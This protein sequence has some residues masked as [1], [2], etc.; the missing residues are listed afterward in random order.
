[1]YALGAVT[2]E[3]LTGEPPFSGATVQAIVAKVLTEKPMSPTAVRDTVPRHIEATLLKAL[4]KLPADRFAT[5]ALFAESLAR[6]EMMAATGASTAG[7]VTGTSP[8][9]GLRRFISA[10]PGVWV[11]L[12][13]SIGLAGWGWNR[14]AG[15]AAPQP[16]TR[17][18]MRLGSATILPGLVNPAISP[19]GS[20][21][22]FV[23][24]D[25]MGVTRIYVRTL[26]RFDPVTVSGTEGA[27]LPF[28]SPD[29]ESIGF[30]QDGKLRTVSLR[31]GTVIP[32]CDWAVP[33]SGA[34]WGDDSTIV[35]AAA[36]S[37][38]RVPATGG[39]PVLL[40]AGFAG[41]RG[42][43][44]PS[45]LP[46]GRAVLAQAIGDNAGVVALR[47][48]DSTLTHLVPDGT[49]PQYV[50]G[51]LL[52]YGAADGSV[53]AAPFDPAS[54][55]I[56]GPAEPVTD[57]VAQG[58]AGGTAKFAVA[59]TG[60]LAY[61]TGSSAGGR[62]LV[63]TDRSG[64]AR[65]LPIGKRFYRFPR[66]SPDG[67]QL[68]FHAEV[69]GTVA[70]DLWR[71]TFDGGALIRLTSDSVS[72]QPEW[73]PDGR[74]L[75]YIRRVAG[76]R[77]GAALQ[78]YRVSADG[79]EAPRPVLA[80]PNSIYESRITPDH[81]MIVFREDAAGGGGAGNRDI[82]MAP[83]DSP[84]AVRPLVATPF[85]EKGIALSPDGNWL[86][87]VSN[88]TGA[89]EVYIRKLQDVSSRWPVSKGGGREPRWIRTGEVFFRK[90]DSVMV[91]RVDLGAEPRVTP[92]RLL[93][94]GEYTFT[95]YEPLWD[96]SPDGQRFAFARASAAVADAP[97]ALLLNWADHWKAR[98]K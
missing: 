79:S 2:Y 17:V 62:D 3:M 43:T 10:T 98:Q 78:L 4:A 73:D 63:V 96:V 46:G 50:D 19:D 72:G 12:A 5:A 49:W 38:Y 81:R 29:G 86:A 66:F 42:I 91:S 93:F 80:R 40:Y 71:Y 60:T 92:P 68:A 59:R 7:I 39:V 47:L 14:R 83:L 76:G 8:A 70:G 56:T 85:D 41:I 90:G 35:F 69:R 44:R 28:F 97:M 94:T 61:L 34:A 88:E 82:L 75:V 64:N 30:A 25:S 9:R 84:T 27:A 36:A 77:S 74:S 54:F 13:A 45:L 52:V 37:L 51:G 20:R 57:H 16:I 55:R 24:R 67:Q 1:V 26:D 32:V 11:F 65:V 33:R 53:F 95:G 18:E 58:P 22:A 15:P 89:D 6:P 48:G 23:A 31:G 87:Y 21:I